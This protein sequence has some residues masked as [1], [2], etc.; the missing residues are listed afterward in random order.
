MFVLLCEFRFDSI[1]KTPSNTSCRSTPSLS[2]DDAEADL[3]RKQTSGLH[4]AVQKQEK[5]QKEERC[6]KGKREDQK[7]KES[8]ACG[9]CI[10]FL[11][12]S[13]AHYMTTD[14]PVL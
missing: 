5:R 3:E 9:F 4:S 2:M 11:P 10:P 1:F 8:I 6:V 7:R 12:W 14:I 13:K